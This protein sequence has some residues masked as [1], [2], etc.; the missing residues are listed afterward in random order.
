MPSK[1]STDLDRWSSCIDG[2]LTKEEYIESM[3]KAGSE[4]SMRL[5][6]AYNSRKTRQRRAAGR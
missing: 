5:R 3:K 2:A 1:E 6:S 4:I